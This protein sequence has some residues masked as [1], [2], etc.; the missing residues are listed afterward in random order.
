MK[1]IHFTVYGRSQ[2]EGSKTPWL[3]RYKDG[4]FVRNKRGQP[5]IAT[6]DSNKNLRPWRQQLSDCAKAALAE[7]GG[8]IIARP[9]AVRLCVCFYFEKPV[10]V[11]R[12]RLLPSV[13]PDASKTLRAV[14]DSLSGIIYED[15]AQITDIVVAKRYGIPARAEIQVEIVENAAYKPDIAKELPLFAEVV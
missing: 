12:A 4:S 14:E 15:D 13:K 9:N 10:S 5:V 2:S 7:N 3:P 1:P 8:E 6:M 11:S